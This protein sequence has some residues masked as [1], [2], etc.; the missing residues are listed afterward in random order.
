MK[1]QLLK[2]CLVAILLFISLASY[3]QFNNDNNNKYWNNLHGKIKSC[4]T[5][6]YNVIKGDTAGK[7][8]NLFDSV[9]F[10]KKGQIIKI[11]KSNTVRGADINKRI[12][13]TYKYDNKGNLI[14]QVFHGTDGKAQVKCVYSYLTSKNKVTLKIFFLPE[15]DSSRVTDTY[16]IN[17]SGRILEK[18][19]YNESFVPGVK[20]QYGKT[21]YKYNAKGLR[22]EEI[23]YDLNGLEKSKRFLKYNQN[24]EMSESTYVWLK[25]QRAN[26]SMTFTDT[27]YD[28]HHN[29]LVRNRFIHGKLHSVTE[30]TITYYK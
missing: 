28:K 16:K 12:S 9:V 20:Y 22:V 19:H 27:K 18:Y 2:H 7:Q 29:W 3:G 11:F 8:I 1:L 25:D 21:V 15:K 10:N 4:T 26:E 24:N 5:I 23:G 30:R 6:G 13:N 14:E 17:A